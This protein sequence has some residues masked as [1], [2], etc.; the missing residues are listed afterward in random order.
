[1]AMLSFTNDATKTTDRIR[2]IADAIMRILNAGN[3]EATTIRALNAFETVATATIKPS[4]MRDISVTDCS[5]VVNQ[6]KPE[7]E[8]GGINI[9]TEGVDDP[10]LSYREDSDD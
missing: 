1:M 3:E 7:P 8:P 6:A 5:F 2:E 10:D 4:E 9:S